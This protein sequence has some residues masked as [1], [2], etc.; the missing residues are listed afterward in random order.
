MSSGQYSFEHDETIKDANGSKSGLAL[1]IRDEWQGESRG[2]ETLSGGEGF[3]AS[4]SLA[5]G[6]ADVVSAEVGG[7]RLESLFV[8]EGF[9]SL[10]DDHLN[11][12]MD[13]LDGLREHGRL[14]GVVSH[15]AAMKDRIPKQLIITK[16]QA[17][18][19]VGVN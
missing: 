4:L 1:L 14:I 9:G 12:V 6:L 11:E 15:V 2:A 7:R 10:D 17:G 5:L 19:T 16:S 18:S 13:I 8:D 3:M